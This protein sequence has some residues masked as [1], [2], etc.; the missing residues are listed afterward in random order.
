MFGDLE[1]F[2]IYFLCFKNDLYMYCALFLII[3]YIYITT[4]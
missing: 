2:L 1:C 4:F 3:F